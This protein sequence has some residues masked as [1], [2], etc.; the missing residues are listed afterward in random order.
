MPELQIGDEKIIIR[1]IGSCGICGMKWEDEP[2]TVHCLMKEHIK[3]TGHDVYNGFEEI[4]TNVALEEY[5][6]LC[7]EYSYEDNLLGVNI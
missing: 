3:E 5:I 6:E 2:Y 1:G 4:L 7:M